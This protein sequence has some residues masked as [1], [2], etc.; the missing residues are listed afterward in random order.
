MIEVTS[1]HPVVNRCPEWSKPTAQPLKYRN[2][3]KITI[4][5]RS[6]QWSS[7]SQLVSGVVKTD[8]MAL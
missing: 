3:S 7:S 6:D 5:G 4:F 2:M 1:G 8:C